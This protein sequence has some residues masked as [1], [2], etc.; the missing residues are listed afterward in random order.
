MGI[1]SERT[2]YSCTKKK[3][4]SEKKQGVRARVLIFLLLTLFFCRN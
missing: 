2:Y 3:K 4:L 1:Q